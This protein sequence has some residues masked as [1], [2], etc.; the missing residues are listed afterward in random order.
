MTPFFVSSFPPRSSHHLSLACFS[1]VRPLLISPS[2]S[3]HSSFWAEHSFKLK[4]R[5]GGKSMPAGTG[6]AVPC[7]RDDENRGKADPP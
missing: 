7:M 4:G 2:F 1:L 6:V 5:R 3:I